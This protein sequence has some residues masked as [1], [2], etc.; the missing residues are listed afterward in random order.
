M[1]HDDEAD[2]YRKGMY[3]NIEKILSKHQHGYSRVEFAKVMGAWAVYNY[4]HKAFSWKKLTGAN[5]VMNKP[6]LKKH[7]IVRSVDMSR[8][9]KEIAKMYG[10]SL[11]GITR[12]NHCWIYSH[13]R[14]GKPIEI[15]EEYKF[16]I[17]MAVR[18]D[19]A[20]I[21]TSPTFLACT[22]TGLG[23]SRM[24]FCIGCMAE[25]I[26]SLGYKAIPMCND[27]A[28]SVPMAI[29]AGLGELGRN[30]LLITP[31][32]GSCVRLCKV[33]TNLSLKIDKPIEFGVTEFCKKCKKCAEACEADAIQMEEEQSF[34]IACP[35]NNLGILRWAVNHDKCYK[36]WIENGGDCSNCIAA[37]PFF[38][39]SNQHLGK[40]I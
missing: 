32:Y 4:F 26:R 19:S 37:C 22:E 31:E 5:N 21:R 24:A 18:M 33:F 36:F 30:G 12:I 6:I 16:A 9:V 23:Y 27:T 15:P 14:N 38:P 10:A 17:V 13:D 20:A 1:L 29:D 28:L 35:S 40:D 3:D 8:E 25:F 39:A 2:F 11:V 34:K 7:P